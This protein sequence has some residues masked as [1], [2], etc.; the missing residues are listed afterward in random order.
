MPGGLFVL[1][2]SS[3][4]CMSRSSRPLRF[5][6]AFALACGVCAGSLLHPPAAVAQVKVVTADD[7][8]IHKAI[9]KGQEY[10]LKQLKN[11]DDPT[12]A[13]VVI[14]LVKSGMDPRRSEITGIAERLASH[15]SSSTFHPTK[16]HIY[17][18]AVTLLALSAV[19]AR[20]YRGHIFA[21]TRYLIENQGKEGQWHY[22][23]DL[24]GDTSITQ[25][26]MLALWESARTGVSIPTEVWDK[27]AYW[28]LKTQQ[29]GGGFMYHPQFGGAGVPP[30]G[31]MSILHS[32][33]VAG[34]GS[35]RISRRFLFGD[36][37]TKV[38]EEPTTAT[39]QA[40]HP[41]AP[42]P[43]PKKNRS[44]KRFGIL[45]PVVRDDLFEE[46]AL[47]PVGEPGKITARN[48]KYAA[49]VKQADLDAAVERAVGWLTAN[50][51]VDKPSGYPIYYLYGLERASALAEVK[52]YGGRNWYDEGAAHLLST[53]GP[54][55][56]WQDVSGLTTGTAFAILFLVRATSKM[57]EPEKPRI[58]FGTGILV[59]GRGLPEDLKKPADDDKAKGKQKKADLDDLLAQLENPQI[60]LVESAQ[61]E[62]VEQVI[63]GDR[64][65][66]IGQI[67]RLKKLA[68]HPEPEIRRTALWALG[69]S[70]D[71]RM[72]PILIAALKDSNID[73]FVEARNALR[74]L[75]R[76]VEDFS[77]K[78]NPTDPAARERERQK[79]L[80][81]YK[82]IRDYD[83]RDLLNDS[84]AKK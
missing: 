73:V 1:T 36:A 59:G 8:Q 18:A 48:S 4:G 37:K 19:D 30:L 77:Q 28:H 50:F 74:C 84:D 69:R 49:S 35:L 41:S 12:C 58:E 71:L 61:S 15:V 29:Q 27:A 66:L 53:Q 44:G 43:P 25:Y 57:V 16:H 55:G 80:T 45:E 83:Q 52:D 47:L 10:L 76:R 64:K 81:W 11:E 38:I 9:E 24:T 33:T 34:I 65:K 21:I 79:W 63:I 70:D 5:P 26:A 20:K 3:D 22:P 72:A 68:T 46:S 39:D 54:N 7:A 13:L 17:E 2:A 31:N 82:Q 51:T 67:D 14:A 42:P 78:D 60:P 23:Y 32:M 62:I 75:S 6:L 40:N 56:E